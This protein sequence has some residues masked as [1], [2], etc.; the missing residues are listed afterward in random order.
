MGKAARDSG[1]RRLTQHSPALSC[2]QANGDSDQDNRRMLGPRYCS[3]AECHT[4]SWDIWAY[5][6]GGSKPDAVITVAN[7]SSYGYDANGN[8]VTATFGYDGDG[9]MVTATIGITTTYYV[10]SY[11]EKSGTITRTYYYHIGKRV[12][13]PVLAPK[14]R[15][16][17][18]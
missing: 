16:K 3:G 5:G 6:Y 14:R 18:A 12:A 15:C 1:E 11:F 13:T 4:T 10:G 17:C 2:L 7:V 9:K 8:M